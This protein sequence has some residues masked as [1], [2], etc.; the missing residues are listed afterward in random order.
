MKPS[1]V[2]P[3][4]LHAQGRS[5][6]EP[7]PVAEL[8]CH[9]LAERDAPGIPVASCAHHIQKNNIVI[10]RNRLTVLCRLVGLLSQNPDFAGSKVTTPAGCSQPHCNHSVLKRQAI[11]ALWIVR[12]I[13]YRPEG[14]LQDHGSAPDCTGFP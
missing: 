14:T 8:L 12:E 13:A 4:A 3:A 2:L 10:S 7:L 9:L 1:G 11:H 6:L 5:V